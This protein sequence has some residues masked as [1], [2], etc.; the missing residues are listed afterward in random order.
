[1]SETAWEPAA[2]RSPLRESIPLFASLPDD[3]A[4]ILR[5]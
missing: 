2:S 1:M 5:V 4:P 3:G